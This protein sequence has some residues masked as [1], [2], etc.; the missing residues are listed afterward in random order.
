MSLA[1]SRDAWCVEKLVFCSSLARYSSQVS[2]HCDSVQNKSHTFSKRQ[3]ISFSASHKRPALMQP[4]CTA[5]SNPCHMGQCLADHPQCVSVG[6]EHGKTRLFTPIRSKT[7]AIP[8]CA[9]HHSVQLERSSPPRSGD[10]SAGKR[11][12]RNQ[13]SSPERVRLLQPLLPRPQKRWWPATYSRSQTPEIRPDE[14]VIQD[15]HFETDPLANMP[16]GLVY[17]AGSERRILSHPGS[18]PITDYS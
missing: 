3:Q 18:P 7:T 15:D 17:V 2:D 5:F 9:R 6:N 13:S 10:E 11:S 8:W 12:H 4:V 1:T 16:R 14:K